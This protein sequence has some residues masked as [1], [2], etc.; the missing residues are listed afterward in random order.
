MCERIY[1]CVSE[2]GV[3]YMASVFARA[4]VSQT[5]PLS[6]RVRG[7]YIRVWVYTVCLLRV[8]KY[9]SDR[10]SAGVSAPNSTEK[11]LA[12]DQSCR[13]SQRNITG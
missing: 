12:W 5:Q 3:M 6:L 2:E 7:L 8:Q 10:S 1:E 4:S 11:A 13:I 9:K